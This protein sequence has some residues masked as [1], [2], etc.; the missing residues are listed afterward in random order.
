[1]ASSALE[2]RLIT[3]SVVLTANSH[4]GGLPP[5]DL[6]AR[7]SSATSQTTSP[8]RIPSLCCSEFLLLNWVSFIRKRENAQE[9]Y[10]HLRI[11]TRGDWSASVLACTWALTESGQQP[12]RLRSSPQATSARATNER[13]QHSWCWALI[14]RP[15]SGP[16]LRNKLKNCPGRFAP[17]RWELW[18]RRVSR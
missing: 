6:T 15:L 11:C 9:S 14:N 4:S 16:T 7:D 3:S 8:I 13:A 2:P 17:A 1:M 18:D 12:R 5:A 10:R